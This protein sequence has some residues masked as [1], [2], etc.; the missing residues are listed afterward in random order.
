MMRFKAVT[1]DPKARQELETRAGE[2][3]D[4]LFSQWRDGG[5][6]CGYMP[7]GTPSGFADPA[8]QRLYDA[9]I[10]LSKEKKAP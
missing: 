4:W 6:V 7:L 1:D 10:Y 8:I 3:A 2:F 9:L 5:L